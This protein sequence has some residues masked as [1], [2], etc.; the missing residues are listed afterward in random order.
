MEKKNIP[1]HAQ[2]INI[3]FG[4]RFKKTFGNIADALADNL[5]FI[6]AALNG[7]NIQPV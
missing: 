7:N 1:K 6:A 2:R 5:T 3:L 4:K